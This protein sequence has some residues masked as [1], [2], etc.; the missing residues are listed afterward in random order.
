MHSHL[1]IS[2][3]CNTYNCRINA[4][5]TGIHVEGPTRCLIDHPILRS[6][7]PLQEGL[8]K[9]PKKEDYDRKKAGATEVEGQ[10]HFYYKN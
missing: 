5:A 2:E 8:K 1:R 3:S 9:P 4:T 6:L 10:E 7:L